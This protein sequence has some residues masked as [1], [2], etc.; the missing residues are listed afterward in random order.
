[1]VLSIK[2]PE[3]DKLARDLSAATGQTITAVVREALADRL[4]AWRA[5]QTAA[6]EP[7]VWAIIDR[8]RQR[9]ILDRRTE[10][11]ILGYNEL[12]LPE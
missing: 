6:A 5:R 7:D 12:G 3:T 10:D 8:G 11:E 4:A 2:D 9:S 1:M